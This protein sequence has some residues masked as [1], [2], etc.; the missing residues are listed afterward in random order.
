MIRTIVCL[1]AL[2]LPASQAV[3]GDWDEAQTAGNFAGARYRHDDGGSLL[4]VCDTSNKRI[5]IMLKEPRA[6]WKEGDAVGVIT[7]N[8]KGDG[9]NTSK[10]Q[11]VSSTVVLAQ[12]NDLWTMSNARR[13]FMVSAG[14]Y[15]RIYPA[16]GFKS[17]TEPV[18]RACGDTWELLRLLQAGSA[19]AAST[20][21]DHRCEPLNPRHGAGAVLNQGARPTDGR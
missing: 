17:A 14:N 2:A 3:C 10:G 21:P 6:N 4:V 16:A 9:N 5:R 13:F 12:A 20:C 8:D 19:L 11:A 15:A 1:A 7:K 18:L